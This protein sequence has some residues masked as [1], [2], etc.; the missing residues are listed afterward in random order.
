MENRFKKLYESFSKNEL[1]RMYSGLTG[2]WEQDSKK[3]TRQQE[4]LE[5]LAG[6]V[7]VKETE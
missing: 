4:E 1:K 2:D 6:I 5:K 7:D 3:F